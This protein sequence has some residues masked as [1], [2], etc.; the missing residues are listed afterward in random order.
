MCIIHTC[1]LKHAY[2][3]TYIYIYIYIHTYIHTY[4]HIY[5][6][7]L[8]HTHTHSQTSYKNKH[9][10]TRARADTHTH[11]HACIHTYMH[12]HIHTRM[13][14]IHTYTKSRIRAYRPKT[15]NGA[16]WMFTAQ[17]PWRRTTIRMQ[18]S[19]SGKT[20][21]RFLYVHVYLR[22]PDWLFIY[23]KN[24]GVY[25]HAFPITLG[26]H[27]GTFLVYVTLRT[28]VWLRDWQSG[29]ALF[30]TWSKLLQIAK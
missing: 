16:G 14:K 17:I 3:H 15:W 18:M 30:D 5:I 29:C 10:S 12:T 6:Y 27:R 11:T 13:H 1:I 22:V 2:I 7:T 25:T 28:S 21:V 20:Y 24:S 9:T 4:I 8:I 19:T 23:S 26:N